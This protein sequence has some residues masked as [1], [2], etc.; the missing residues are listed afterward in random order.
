MKMMSSP[1]SRRELLLL[2]TAAGAAALMESPLSAQPQR[3]G[4]AGS[5]PA[6]DVRSHG[7]VGDARTDDT[8]AFQRALDAARVE[9]LFML[10]QGGIFSRERSMCRLA[11]P[12]VGRSRAFLLIRESGTMGSRNQVMMEPPSL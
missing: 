2:G 10:Q 3:A 6:I 8:A 9:E 7:A 12:Y 5:L 1:R 11:L 4:S